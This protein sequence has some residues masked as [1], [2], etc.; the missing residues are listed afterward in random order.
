MWGLQTELMHDPTGFDAIWSSVP[1]E[2][3]C[4]PHPYNF[5]RGWIHHRTILP[6]CFPVP[7]CSCPVGPKPRR[8]FAVPETEEV[9]L[10]RIQLSHLC[11]LILRM[12]ASS[13]HA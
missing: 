11:A 8:I 12:H 3:Q 5:L 1:V 4:F 6:R 7:R 13:T 2:H 9:P 10:I